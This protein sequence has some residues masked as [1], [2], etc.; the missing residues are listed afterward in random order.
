M[1]RKVF[2]GPT[3][4]RLRENHALTQTAFAQRLGLSVSYLNQ[5]EN[6]Q[7]P[8]TAGVLLALGQTFG[9]DLASFASDDTDRL[10]TDLR[11][12]LA[13]PLFKDAGPALQD[14]KRV[15]SDAPVFAKAFL[16][17]HQTARRLGERL[18]RG[19]D[20]MLAPTDGGS[21]DALLPYEEVR[22]YFHYIDN[23]VDELDRPAEELAARLALTEATDRLQVLAGYLS[24]RHGMSV[25]LLPALSDGMLDHYHDARKTITLNAALS[26]SAHAFLLATRIAR[27]EQEEAMNLVVARAGF[28]SVAAQDICRVA[29][30]NH[31]AGA[32]VMPYRAF[33]NYAK[34]VRHDFDR[35]ASR[36]GVS[37]EQVGHRLAS[38][39]RP[40]LKGIPFYFFKVDRAGN[41]IKR[42]SATRFQ[43]ARFGGAC[44]LWNVYDAFESGGRTLVQIGEMPDGTRYLSLG[45]GITYPGTHWRAPVRRYAIGLGCEVSYASD[46]VYSEGLDLRSDANVT[47]F[48]VSCRICERNDCQNRAAPPIDRDIRVPQQS[49]S[50]VPFELR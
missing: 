47:R 4:R 45:R 16:R 44:P 14:I 23:Y 19:G 46:I 40:G 42:H 6:N 11:E 24:S 39:Q 2:V 5:I 17:L 22:D 34:E 32:L 28:R 15:A 3:V 18:Q 48:G 7:R 25:E 10:V 8:V 27:L 50:V 31:Y 26:P 1:S 12:A 36:F 21:D 9:V 38:L 49:R 33:L 41:V 43:F 35:M 20:P 30:A 37:I 13:D 29:L